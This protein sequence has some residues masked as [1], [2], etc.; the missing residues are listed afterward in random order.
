MNAIATRPPTDD[1][2]TIRPCAARSAGSSAC[3]TATWPNTLTSNCLRRSSGAEQLQ[4]AA[5]ADAG[6]V[7]ERVEP[8]GRVAAAELCDARG[9]LADLLEVGHVEQQR[10]QTPARLLRREA[11]AGLFV[12]HAGEHRPAGGGEVQRRRLADA[13]GRT[14]DEGGGHRAKTSSRPSWPTLGIVIDG[15]P[16]RSAPADRVDRCSAMRKSR[17]R[18][19]AAVACSPR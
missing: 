2:K 18:A 5:I 9:R 3:V 12:A 1:R 11:L 6:V 13:R 15:S 10:V 8:A 7:D 17:S 19:L 4:R 14:G 16:V